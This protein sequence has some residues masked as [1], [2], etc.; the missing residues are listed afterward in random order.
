VNLGRIGRTAI[1]D[2]KQPALRAL[3][4]LEDFN[5]KVRHPKAATEPLSL[6]A[7]QLD[8]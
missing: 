3:E 2:R 4:Q 8:F 5:F 1:P 7:L 6:F